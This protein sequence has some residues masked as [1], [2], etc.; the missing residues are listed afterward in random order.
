[1]TNSFSRSWKI[2][3]LSFSV[4][5]KDKELLAFPIL[6]FI[7]SAAFIIAMIL[8]SILPMLLGRTS[9]VWGAIQYLFIFL[10]YLGLAFFATFFNVCVVYT[11]KKR[12]EGGNATFGESIRFALSKIHLVLMWSLLSATVGLL[13]RILDNMARNQKGV[14]R[15]LFLIMN[16]ILG[17]MWSIVIIFVVPGMVYHDLGPID[18]IKRSVKTLRKT[19]GESLIRYFG[20]GLVQGM[21]LI[22]GIIVLL[23]IGYLS[24]SAGALG[25]LIV[26]GIGLVYIIGLSLVFS[27][28][29]S[30]FNTALYVY[31][32]IGK[33]PEGY[34]A[35]TLHDTFH[36]KKQGFMNRGIV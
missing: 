29:N 3:K 35:E 25:I 32:D 14:G 18:A 20:L 19:W 26:V 36:P 23:P 24:L 9:A 10:I 7:F 27:V 4:I 17:L 33:I 13:L 28:A 8:P 6:A 22:I 1:M 30:I 11:T 21:L 15:I 34:D 31:A 2:T 16:S 12:F 5:N